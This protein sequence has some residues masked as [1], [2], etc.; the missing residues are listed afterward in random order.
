MKY[1][2]NCG[3]KI[4]DGQK[5]CGKCGKGVAM[6]NKT[7]YDTANKKVKAPKNNNVSQALIIVISTLV[8]IL[9]ICLL[10]FGVYKLFLSSSNS[11][12]NIS[13]SGSHNSSKSIKE[14]TGPSIDILSDT[15]SSTFMNQDQKNGFGNVNLG[16]TKSEIENKFGESEDTINIAGTQAEKYG[17]IAVKYENDVVDR[18]FVVPDNVSIYQ[19][20]DFHGN[21]TMKVD[22][23]VIYDDNANN[24]FTIKVYTNENDEVIGI[25]NINQ[26]DRNI[27]DASESEKVTSENQARSM[28][29]NYLDETYG[30]YWIHSVDENNGVY[31][32]NYGKGNAS[33]AHDAVYIYQ[34]TGT[35]TETNPNE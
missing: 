11:N 10:L 5:F 12:F 3:D 29:V 23:G 35:I 27:T 26:I 16:M 22:D 18:Y 31:R 4:Q 20:E 25:E 14:N 19:F 8:F 6:Y 30:E 7:V 33:H 21:S 32:V 24:S 2:N 34:E 1:C 28:A 17:S 13:S 15:F 9:L